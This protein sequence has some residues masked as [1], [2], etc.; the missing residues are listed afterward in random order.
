MFKSEVKHK[1]PL[2]EHGKSKKIVRE[3]NQKSEL[4]LEGISKPLLQS[5]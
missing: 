1:V 3:T 2:T 4:Y 5:N